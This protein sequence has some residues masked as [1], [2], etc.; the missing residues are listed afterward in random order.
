MD[1]LKQMLGNAN[2]DRDTLARAMKEI[3]KG[4][5]DMEQVN[6][7]AS[8]LMATNEEKDPRKRLQMKIA[9]KQAM[10]AH[11]KPEAAAPAAAQTPSPVPAATDATTAAAKAAKARKQKLRELEKKYGKI[12]DDN[13]REALALSANEKLTPSDRAH[14]KNI[15]DLYSKQNEFKPQIDFNDIDDI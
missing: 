12:S 3:K 9:S 2:L 10:R 7:I 15:V 6:R 4:N 1:E 11:K 8:Q 14:Y 13:Y 5:I